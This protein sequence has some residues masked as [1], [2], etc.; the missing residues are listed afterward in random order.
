MLLLCPR[1]K[2]VCTTCVTKQGNGCSQDHEQQGE[3]AVKKRKKEKTSGSI[4]SN[5]HQRAVHTFILHIIIHEPSKPPFPFFIICSV[6]IIHIRCDIRG[7]ELS[8]QLTKGNI[9]QGSLRSGPEGN[10]A[11]FQRL[12]S[13]EKREEITV[14]LTRRFS[15]Q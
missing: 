4:S 12:K 8:L 5:K 1:T 14:S 13:R 3:K 7:S 15:P 11:V 2:S 10:E 6:G 9:L